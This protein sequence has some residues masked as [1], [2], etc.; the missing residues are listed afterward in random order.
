MSQHLACFISALKHAGYVPAEEAKNLTSRHANVI[1]LAQHVAGEMGL[2]APELATQIARRFNVPVFDISVMNPSTF[3]ENIVDIKLVEKYSVLPLFKR[4]NQLFLAVLDPTNVQLI[5]EITFTARLD[6]NIVVADAVAM[7]VATKR[8]REANEVNLQDIIGGDDVDMNSPF[9]ALEVT[10]AQ[11]DISSLG[12]GTDD[13][14]VV[15]YVQ[16]ILV[17]AVSKGAS[18][19]HVEPF[20]KQL[21]VR[22]RVDGILYTIASQP[23]ALARRMVARIKIL[24]QLDIAER[25]VPQDGRMKMLLT[26]SKSIDL[27]VNTLPTIYG[28]KVVLRILDSQSTPLDLKSLGFDKQQLESY[29]AAIDRPYGMILITGP[30]GSGKTVTLYSALNMLNQ[31]TKNILTVEDPVEIQLNGIIQ[32]NINEKAN[33]GFAEALRAFLRQDP[34]IIMVGEIRDLETA[35]IAIKA[36]QTGHL[37]LS[38]LHTNSAPAT[39]TRLINMGIPAY[40]LGSAVQLIAAQRLLRLLCSDCKVPATL[41][42]DVLLKAGFAEHQLEGLQLYAANQS[43][44]ADC[45]GGYRSRIAIFQVMPIS[46]RLR[47]VMIEG[48]N[49][50]QLEKIAEEEGVLSLR[51]SGLQKV[52]AGVTSLEE[53]DRVTNL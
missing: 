14:P 33:L 36:S 30:T 16:R 20:E 38:T 21:R 24:S 41:P 8:F 40:N 11:D 49:E 32:V 25:R 13:A 35:E 3:P 53:V 6:I 15:T 2:T 5:D 29:K 28:E 48:G 44:C 4:G 22:F 27:R 39:L 46:E 37:V 12:V 23:I 51:A 31:P 42:P 10:E 7:E 45:T 26:S 19:I 17:D 1:G 18:D 34:D 9:E 50:Q 52:R 47:S 43:G